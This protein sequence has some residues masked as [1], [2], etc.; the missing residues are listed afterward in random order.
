MGCSAPATCLLGRCGVATCFLLGV[1]GRLA[2][3]S[4]IQASQPWGAG[5]GA[6]ANPERHKGCSVEGPPLSVGPAPVLSVELTGFMKRT[7][8]LGK[9]VRDRGTGD[10]CC[11]CGLCC[12]PACSSGVRAQALSVSPPIRPMRPGS[13][14]CWLLCVLLSRSCPAASFLP[15]PASSGGWLIGAVSPQGCADEKDTWDPG[16]C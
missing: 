4:S 2:V 1:Q 6:G 9:T 12:G 8:D 10:H 5:E 13:E 7:C 11:S 16:Y 15:L 3:G 14:S